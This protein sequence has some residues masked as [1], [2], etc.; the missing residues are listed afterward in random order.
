MLLSGNFEN[1]KEFQY[2]AYNQLGAIPDAWQIIS[3]LVR[4]RNWMGEAI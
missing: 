2:T 3:A 4:Q 1:L